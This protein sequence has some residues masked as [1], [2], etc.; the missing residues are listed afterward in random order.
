[1]KI[2]NKV[3]GTMNKHE[4]KYFSIAILMD[5]ALISLLDKRRVFNSIFKFCKR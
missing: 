5:E 4:S 2:N 3:G 1:M